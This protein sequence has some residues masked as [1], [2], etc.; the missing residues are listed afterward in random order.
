LVQRTSYRTL[1]LLACCQALV[2]ANASGLVSMVALV[3][4]AM[5]ETKALA[6]LAATTYVIGSAV[7]TMPASLWMARVG[8]RRGFMTSAIVNVVG[9]LVAAFALWWN[10]YPLFCVGTAIIGVYTAFG[11]HYRFA[12]AEVATVE[13]RAKAISLVLAGGIVGAFL[14]PAT[15]VWAKDWFAT[16]FLGSLLVLAG[17]AFVALAFQ[18]RVDVCR[19]RRAESGAPADVRSPP[20]FAS[21]CSS[22]PRWPGRSA[23]G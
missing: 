5:V 12:A 20:S 15:S 6:T 18:S 19:R 17:F 3:G 7:T 22:W 8:R 9:C 1:F 10:S 16:P 23:T 13:D 21:R 11:L 14:G 2:I 4:Y